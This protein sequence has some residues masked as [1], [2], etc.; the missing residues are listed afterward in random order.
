MHFALVLLLYTQKY[1]E[2]LSVAGASG[3]AGWE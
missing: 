2:K 3:L 1:G